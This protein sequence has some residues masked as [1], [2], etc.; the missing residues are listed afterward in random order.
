MEFPMQYAGAGPSGSNRGG[1]GGTYD[2]RDHLDPRRLTIVMWDN[3]YV[4][5]HGT[6]GSFEDFDKAL[7][8]AVERGYNTLRLDPMPQWIDLADPGKVLHWDDPKI[9]YMPWNQNAEVE[10]PVGEWIIEF[11]QK[12]R[13]RGLYY[14]LSAWWFDYTGTFNGGPKLL[15]RPTSH[16]EAAEVWAEMLRHWKR[17]L[18]FDGL[19]YLD[20]ANEIPFFLPGFMDKFNNETGSGWGEVG[21]FTPQQV[22]FLAGDINKALTSLQRE[23]PELR[24]TGSIHD[25]VRWLDVPL[26]F[27]CL[28]VHFYI[29]ADER[30]NQRTHFS[31]HMQELFT[32]TSWHADFSDRCTKAIQA[33]GPMCRARQRHRLARFSQWAAER[34]MPLTTSESWAS[35]FYFDSP[36]LDWGWLLEWAENSVDDAIE[37]GMWGWT[38]HNYVQPQFVNWKDVRWHRRLT[39]KFLRS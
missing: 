35:W 16:V 34:G 25:D 39:D 17:L 13:E 37:Y 22:Q 24:F 10:G 6:G 1:L 31:D 11:V 15:H 7:D 28:D 33:A 5:R 19:V 4:M 23:F 27:D 29:S 20:I 14:T 26:E 18:G 3:A 8:E 30:W 36:D 9:P 12:A 2:M 21:A 32:D 38:P